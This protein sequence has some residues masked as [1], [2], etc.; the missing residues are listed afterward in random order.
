M[1]DQ[2]AETIVGALV[3]AVAGAFM[4]YALTITGGAS[5]GGMPLNAR[6][7]SVSGLSVGADV[8]LSGVKV[9]TVRSIEIDP[10]S[11]QA[12]VR[13]TVD[14][15]IELSTDTSVSLA[16]EGLLGGVYLAVEPGG[17]ETLLAA[18]DEVAF[19]QGAI[20]VVRLLADFVLSAQE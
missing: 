11:Y 2:I 10:V 12:Q 3:L 20:D 19:G 13:F 15:A 1:R 18:N 7:E 8:R 4:F 17:E 16:N 6:F 14:P 9:G 5:A